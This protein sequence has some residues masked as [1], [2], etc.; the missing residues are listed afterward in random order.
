MITPWRIGQEELKNIYESAQV[1]MKFNPERATKTTKI[2][3]NHAHF[4]TEKEALEFAIEQMTKHKYACYQIWGRVEKDENDV[5]ILT[6]WWLSTD[7]VEVLES[8][9]YIGMAQLYDGSKILS[10]IDA[11][12]P[13]DNVVAYY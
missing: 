5:Y 13:I 6:N 7:D 9:E 12:I 2:V 11:N 4:S 1:R 3:N 8:A 10:I